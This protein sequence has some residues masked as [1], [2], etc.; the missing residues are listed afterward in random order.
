MKTSNS[1]ASRRSIKS[2]AV[3]PLK[4]LDSETNNRALSLG[5]ADALIT[6]LG[7]LP[8]IRIL[9]V[10]AI[11]RYTD[12][13][14][15]SLEISRKLSV[16]AVM[17]GTLQRANG[18]LRVTL[19]LLDTN[20]GKQLWSHSFDES[21]S[22]IFSLQDAMARQTAEGLAADVIGQ[23]QAKRPTDNLEAYHLY[24]QG[25]YLFRRRE[26]SKGGGF[27]EKAIELDPKFARAYARLAVA[28]AMG[29]AM[30]DAE[31]TVNQALELQPDLA[32]AHAVRGFIKMF[33]DWD[34]A[35]ADESLRRAVELD[36]N[37]VEAHHWRGII[38]RFAGAWRKPK[39]N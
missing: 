29:D 8:E 10:N 36:P 2:I 11:S 15:E 27:F 39:P 26:T 23:D 31:A 34:W 35:A 3:L 32:E 25:Q 28:Y 24:L 18:K 1:T 33:L 38:L 22:N 17:D 4:S 14:Q 19:R 5:F 6:S 30:A 7:K 21:E 13:R 37:S 20:D 16:D 12:E 9:S